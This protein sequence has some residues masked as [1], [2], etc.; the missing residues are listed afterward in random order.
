MVRFAL[1]DWPLKMCALMGLFMGVL[2][3]KLGGKV[4]KLDT[5]RH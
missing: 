3:E 5:C 2:V 1:V 4:G